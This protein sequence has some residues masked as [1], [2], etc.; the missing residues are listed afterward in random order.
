MPF[1]VAQSTYFNVQIPGA[2]NVSLSNWIVVCIAPANV[3]GIVNN[4]S[5]KKKLFLIKY[6]PHNNTFL[7]NTFR[8][9]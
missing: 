5:M 6:A 4:E 2:P 1:I 7:E 3:S 9:A 8:V